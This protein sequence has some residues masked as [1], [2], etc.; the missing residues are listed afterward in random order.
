MS[1]FTTLK[2]LVE[3]KVIQDAQFNVETAFCE[4][5]SDYL[6]DSSLISEFIHSSYYKKDDGG[7][8]SKNKWILYQ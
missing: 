3:E 5:I 1:Y 4:I 6:A 2:A 8:T 7:T